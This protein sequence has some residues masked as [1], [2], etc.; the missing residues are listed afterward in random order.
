MALANGLSSGGTLSKTLMSKFCGLASRQQYLGA[1]NRLYYIYIC[2][3][4]IDI[5]I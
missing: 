3:Y 4:I 1:H 5:K 2:I